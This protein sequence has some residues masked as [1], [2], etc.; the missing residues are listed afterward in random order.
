MP[1]KPKRHEKPKRVP[2]RAKPK[3]R[4]LSARLRWPKRAKIIER[5]IRMTF[6]R[7][8]REG[9][10]SAAHHLGHVERV[11]FYAMKYVEL[12]GASP[13]LRIQAKIAGLT[14]DRIRYP[15]EEI[16]HEEASARFMESLFAKRYGKEATERITE[17]IAKHG[18]L[19]ALSEVGRNVVRDAVVFADKFFE[20]NGAYIA[21]RRAMFMGERKDRREEA[22]RKGYNLNTKEGR[23]KAAVE[24]T[25]DETNKR[26]AKFSD[27]SKIPEFLHPFV[28]YQV[29][30]QIKLR[31]ALQRREHSIVNM[32]T[33]L[34][35][36]GL[37]PG[38]ERRPLDE[39]IKSYKPIGKLDAEF[40]REALRYLNG[41]LWEEFVKRVKVPK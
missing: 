11:S 40:K 1:A 21:F 25:L 9:K 29:S 10:L 23:K 5:Y 18:K 3:R 31:D 33:Y 27:L 41:E 35:E 32:V 36:E 22:R 17:A 4:K 37:K 20:A 39:V 2:S 8:A 13:V 7:L 30:W 12:L 28:K 24:F 15:T 19:P 14:H 26:I 16:P 34:F 6:N 38:K